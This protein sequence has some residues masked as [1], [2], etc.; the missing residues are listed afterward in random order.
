[1]LNLLQI[2]N[3]AVIEQAE[4]A[5][6]RGLNV[7]TGETGAGKSIVI[8]SISAI[9]GARTYR[10][11]IRTGCDRAAVSAVFSYIPNYEWFERNGVPYADEL[12]IRRELYAD[13]RNACRVNGQVISVAL[14]RELGKHL[15]SIH[16][17][18]DTQSLF[19]E[20]THLA[21]LDA[22]APNDDKQ[23]AFNDAYTAYKAC[24][25]AVRQLSM[26]VGERMRRTEMLRNEVTEIENAAVSVGE[27]DELTSKQRI[28]IHAER[29]S[30]GLAAALNSLYGDESSSGAADLLSNAEK[31]LTRLGSVD[32]AFSQQ[33]EQLSQLRYA[34]DD[35]S[36]NLR[37]QFEALSYSA[38]ELEI[39]EDRLALLKKLKMKFGPSLTD[40]LTYLKNAKDELDAL[41]CSDE[42]LLKR[43]EEL[44]KAE[45]NAEK[46]A[47]ALHE[48]RV[49][50][51]QMLQSRMEDEL[52]QLAMP[53]FRFKAEIEPSELQSSGMDSVRFLMSAN[54]GES[55]KPLSKIASGGELAR[56][57]LSLESILSERGQVQT[58]IFDEVDAGVSGR[59]AQKV[60]EKLL[61][62]AS[63]KQVL[64]VTHLAQIAAMADTH[65]L[66]SKC[67]KNG[68]TFTSVQKLNREQR[69]EELARIIGGADITQT[70]RNSAEEMLRLN[71]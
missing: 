48:E 21:L 18:N 51:A 4:I 29:V 1:M 11:L 55:L 8:D 68:R 65:M 62:A 71:A 46:A 63:G 2:E 60:A 40:V 16:G 20:Q 38:N 52:S 67:V 6:D 58:M 56:I 27:D 7:L 45:L 13:G 36:Q 30:D 25:D 32:E 5:F 31:E 50:T 54:V 10:D 66:I 64:C 37:D 12:F 41:D 47:H 39:I 24:A 49:Q 17:Q 34:M 15:I 23:T 22:L 59:A 43:K 35:L 26:D 14:L 57:M 69:V 19:D 70:T 33:A 53:N 61:G 3:I 9:L 28:L 42:M 44:A